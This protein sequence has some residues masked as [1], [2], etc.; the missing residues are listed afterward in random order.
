MGV[1]AVATNHTRNL[2][3]Q[4]I[5]GGRARFGAGGALIGLLLVAC[6]PADSDKETPGSPD[7]PADSGLD[8]GLGG[9]V[10]DLEPS[11]TATELE[12]AVVAALA[13]GLPEP[14]TMRRWFFDIA[15]ISDG[16][17][18]EVDCPSVPPTVDE[19]GIDAMWLG[20]CSSDEY[21]LNGGWI[22]SEETDPETGRLLGTG[23]YTLT[24]EYPDGTEIVAGGSFYLSW[25][26]VT[27]GTHSNLK[28]GGTFHDPT[29]MGWLGQGVSSG[30]ELEGEIVNGTASAEIDGSVGIGDEDF[31]YFDNVLFRSEHCGT[32][33]YGS[34]LVRDPSSVWITVEFDETCPTCGAAT[35]GDQ[36]LGEVCVAEELYEAV[37]G[38]L[39]LKPNGTGR[40]E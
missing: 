37:H 23:L 26:A 4:S 25:E 21:T 35:W 11:W 40:D 19:T 9:D 36:E 6:A 27:G 1:Y 33:P 30:V 22:Y 38:A 20:S 31:L 34:L 7:A 15:H 24:G 3:G 28:L 32:L 18:D 2:G 29:E 5:V 39:D 13:Y 14:M 17:Y 16:T 12:A 8:S 10:P